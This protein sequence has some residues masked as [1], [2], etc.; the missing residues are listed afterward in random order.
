MRGGE[1]S[2]LFVRNPPRPLNAL[3]FA[4]TPPREGNHFVFCFIA[5]HIFSNSRFRANVRRCGYRVNIGS[6]SHNSVTS[7]PVSRFNRATSFLFRSK[8]SSPVRILMTTSKSIGCANISPMIQSAI[9]S[10][11]SDPIVIN[12]PPDLRAGYNEIIHRHNPRRTRANA[13][14]VAHA[15]NKQ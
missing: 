2:F 11:A 6:V 9:C 13:A 5:A 10:R 3:R 12:P 4:S 14:G 15:R 7:F 1:G 8:Y